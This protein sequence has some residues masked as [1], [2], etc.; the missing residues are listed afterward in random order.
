MRDSGG[1]LKEYFYYFLGIIPVSAV[2][3]WWVIMAQQSA[4]LQ[5]PL[6]GIIGAVL[7]ALIFV[8]VGEWVH[9]SAKAE[10][11]S[12]AMQSTPT[13]SNQSREALAAALENVADQLAKAPPVVIGQQTIAR[14]GPGGGTVIGEQVTATAGPG[15]TGTVIGKRIGASS[16]DQP[17]NEQRAQ[18]LR[19]GAQTVRQ[20]TVTRASIQSLLDQSSLPGSATPPP[21]REAFDRATAALAA[22]DLP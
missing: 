17:F 4:T 8:A 3:V 15:T 18:E 2:A 11:A 19:Q 7:G 21:L 13:A 16:G 1:W 6:L 22:S 12:S 14:G 5:K 9:P 10:G 20:G